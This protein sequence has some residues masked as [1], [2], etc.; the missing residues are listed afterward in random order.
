MRQITV[1]SENTV[2]GVGLLAEHGLAFWIAY[3]DKKILFDTGQGLVLRHNAQRMG[4]P[5]EQT[6][7]VVLSHGHYDH[8]GGLPEVLSLAGD[9]PVILHEAAL[10][11]RY[12]ANRTERAREI[13][14]P[15]ETADALRRKANLVYSNRVTEVCP[16]VYA[17]GPI[18]R[19][20]AFEESDG[21]FFLD[22]A[23]QRPD[24][25]TDDQALFFDTPHGIVVL[26]GCAH[27]GAINTLS[28][29]QTLTGAQPFHAVLGGM[30]LASAGPERRNR[31]V[32]ALCTFQLRRV[33]PGHCTGFPAMAQLCSVFAGQCGTCPVGSVFSF[34]E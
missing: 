30:H 14:M 11:P 22:E 10:S 31:T 4:V 33:F 28:Y 29:V 32:D 25:F 16:G 24:P 12:T 18:P 1:L 2:A 6:S 20:Q 21:K 23:C 9:I 7:A 27:A 19:Q 15:R 13:G 34:T 8:T 5:L 17:T 3:D 26:L